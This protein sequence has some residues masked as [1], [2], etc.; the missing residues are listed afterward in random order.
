MRRIGSTKAKARLSE[1]LRAVEPGETVA[2]TRLGKQI[3]HPMPGPAEARARRERAVARFR[4][5]RAGWKS[6]KFSTEEI[7]ASRHEGHRL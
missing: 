5:H 2:F 6:V 3:A 4:R 7:L 1:L